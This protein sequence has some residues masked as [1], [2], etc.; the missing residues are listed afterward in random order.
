MKFQR[1][2]IIESQEVAYLDIH[3]PSCLSVF[4]DKVII[5]ERICIGLYFRR[6]FR[7]VYLQVVRIQRFVVFQTSL[8]A[9]FQILSLI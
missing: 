2:W 1:Q 8:G 9:I 5:N 4:P 7:I 3:N 6:K